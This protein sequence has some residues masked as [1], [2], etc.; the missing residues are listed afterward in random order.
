MGRHV[1]S[2]AICTIQHGGE[3]GEC[4]EEGMEDGWDPDMA[5]RLLIPPDPKLDARLRALEQSRAAGE[6]GGP[7]GGGGV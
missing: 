1:S 2:A 5:S 3:G 7:G 6:E 4:E